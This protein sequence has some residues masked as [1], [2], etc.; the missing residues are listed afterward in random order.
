[1]HLMNLILMMPM[2][3]VM[4]MMYPV[5]MLKG[6]LLEL[7]IC[8][9]I[10]K[11]ISLILLKLTETSDIPSL[12]AWQYCFLSS[13]PSLAVKIFTD[14]VRA[15]LEYTFVHVCISLNARVLCLFQLFIAL[16]LFLLSKPFSFL[17]NTFFHSIYE[18]RILFSFLR[19]FVLLF[20]LSTDHFNF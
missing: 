2:L 3:L 10:S 1:M 15:V 8:L 7:E 18:I 5:I 6:N 11:I 13:I 14:R 9:Y 12:T 17:C 4:I 16:N 19:V 20:I